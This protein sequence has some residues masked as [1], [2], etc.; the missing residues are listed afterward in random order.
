MKVLINFATSPSRRERY[1]LIWSIPVGLGA[2]T[3]LVYFAV[4]VAHDLM[5]YRAY[6]QSLL[7]AQA[8]EARWLETEKSLRH[9]I[10]RPQSQE[11][12]R[13]VRFVNTLIDKKEFSLA[14]FMKKVAKL[15]PPSVRLD[16]LSFPPVES[17]PVVRFT[18]AGKNQEAAQTFLNNLEDSAD[19]KDVTVVSQGQA[20]SGGAG[21]QFT[22]VCTA[23]YVA[24]ALD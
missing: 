9:E 2:A 10:E 13:E 23:L 22:L 18:V 24:K 19:F 17:D 8:Q 11:A 3:V 21:N 20:E 14:E 12:F 15:L 6:H 4:A 1:A 5:H 7:D 16:G